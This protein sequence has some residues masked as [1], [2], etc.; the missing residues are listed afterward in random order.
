MLRSG[1]RLLVGE[2]IRRRVTSKGPLTNMQLSQRLLSFRAAVDI[3]LQRMTAD[4]AVL[5]QATADSDAANLSSPEHSLSF[6]EAVSS[7]VQYRDMKEDKVKELCDANVGSVYDT[8]PATAGNNVFSKDSA[9]ETATDSVADNPTQSKLKS[10][11]A[12]SMNQQSLKEKKIDSEKQKID[13]KKLSNGTE[14]RIERKF[15]RDIATAISE[16]RNS[17]I[18][19]LIRGAMQ[20]EVT[21]R[22]ID[23][24]AGLRAIFKKSILMTS[25][26]GKLR[27]RP[28]DAINL[29]E[30]TKFILMECERLEIVNYEAFMTAMQIVSQ[31]R[32]PNAAEWL[33]GK[34]TASKLPITEHFQVELTKAFSGGLKHKDRKVQKHYAHRVTHSYY[35]C[36]KLSKGAISDRDFY[37]AAAQAHAIL[38]M[39]SENRFSSRLLRVF[40]AMGEAGFEP[41]FSLCHFV[42]NT[43]LV[44]NSSRVAQ[45]LLQWCLE[46]FEHP[47]EH[48]V[49]SEVFSMALRRNDL[50]LAKIALEL[51]KKSHSLRSDAGLDNMETSEVRS[52]DYCTVLAL[53]V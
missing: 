38:L 12:L 16:S 31:L 21:L 50:V 35:N 36:V 46:H 30:V 44:A 42:L 37:V 14:K 41:D 4:E 1:G 17:F 2:F 48:G 26:P 20:N 25:T 8:I 39:E 7:S 24:K 53:A 11:E 23:C 47:L 10:E 52:V 9:A 3:S 29:W 49:L 34:F 51:R 40:E 45:P 43:S 15:Q 6:R 32:H 28:D 13:G 19:S 5:N 33:F 22:W 27:S 18:V